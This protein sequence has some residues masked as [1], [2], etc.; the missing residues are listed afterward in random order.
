MALRIENFPWSSVIAAEKLLHLDADAC[1]AFPRCRIFDH[2]RLQERLSS[3]YCLHHHHCGRAVL[4]GIGF[5]RQRLPVTSQEGCRQ[6][7][8]LLIKLFIKNI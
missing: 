5:V 6:A 3:V 8:V 4:F 2:C 1:K 7:A